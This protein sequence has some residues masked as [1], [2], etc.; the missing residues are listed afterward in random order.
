MNT[1]STDSFGN[2][3]LKRRLSTNAASITIFRPD[4]KRTGRVAHRIEQFEAEVLYSDWQKTLLF[5]RSGGLAPRSSH[6]G[7]R[8][9]MT[10]FL[11]SCSGSKKSLAFMYP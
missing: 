7:I 3:V 2:T 5:E 6:Q 4:D 11:S 9:R 8:P 10:G 1:S